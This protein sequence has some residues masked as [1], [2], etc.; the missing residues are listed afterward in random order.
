MP[1]APAASVTG[2]IHAQIALLSPHLDGR[3]LADCGVEGAD[4]EP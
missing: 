4:G 2:L 1:V 3:A